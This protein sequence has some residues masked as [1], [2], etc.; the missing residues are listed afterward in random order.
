MSEPTGGGSPLQ[1][2]PMRIAVDSPARRD[3]TALLAEHLVD[4]AAT[5]PPESMHALDVASL[6]APAVTF[7][8]ARD[9]RGDLL[10]CAALQDLSGAT[11]ELKS[12]RT[13]THARRTGVAAALLAALVADARARAW[14]TLF[15]E[16][17]SQAFFAPARALYHR[18]GFIPTTPFADY[19]LDANS[20]HLRLDLARSRATE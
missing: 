16:T 20:V 2:V 19:S 17:G 7:F 14:T 12:M 1:R 4:M 6:Q 15:L 8:T 10:G 13:A 5:S 3:V 18:F 9:E 11:G